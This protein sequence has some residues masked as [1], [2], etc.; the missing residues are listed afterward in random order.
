MQ[1]NESDAGQTLNDLLHI[2]S[3][4]FVNRCPLACRLTRLVD[5]SFDGL[6]QTFRHSYQFDEAAQD[7]SRFGG[8]P[9]A[10]LD[11]GRTLVLQHVM[12]DFEG[13]CYYGAC[14]IKEVLKNST[15][16]PENAAAYKPADLIRDAILPCV[17]NGGNPDVLMVSPDFLKAFAVWESPAMRS[18]AGVN[19]YGTPISAF[20]VA[21]L[22]DVLVIP[23]PLLR[24]GTAIALCSKHV[25]IRL[26]QA[27]FDRTL[28]PKEGE[29][30]MEGA[31]E[32]EN[33]SHHAWVSGVTGFA[34]A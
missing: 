16:E 18:E 7:D 20:E 8:G 2:A 23:A 30:V 29:F 26:K 17:V 4:Y 32:I 33:E 9:P 15:T 25:R 34:V 21:F 28:G 22:K 27:P 1:M 10:P 3:N 13:A 14:G 5:P 12:D 31:I 24:S 19:L 11:R 6:C